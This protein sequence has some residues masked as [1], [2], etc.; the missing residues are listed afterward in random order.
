MRNVNSNIRSIEKLD[1]RI[2][3]SDGEECGRL[4]KN[5]LALLEE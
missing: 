1:R 3:L 5:E 4:D 2:G